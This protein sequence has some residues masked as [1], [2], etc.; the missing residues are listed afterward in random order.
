MNHTNK[1]NHYYMKDINMGNNFFNAVTG[2][3]I[4]INDVEILNEKNYELVYEDDN[5]IRNPILYE[6]CP[7][8][9]QKEIEFFVLWNNFKDSHELNE[10]YDKYD[11][12]EK[13]V[14]NFIK[15]K[16]DY[17]KKND[18]INELTLFLNFLLDIGEISFSFCHL[19][20][21]KIN[22]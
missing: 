11:T 8:L 4:D 22:L 2:Q 16:L 12:V 14:K 9:N 6:D 10:K 20:T 1:N 18:L 13:F 7:D 5:R 3:H 21:I 15:E 19:W 17:L